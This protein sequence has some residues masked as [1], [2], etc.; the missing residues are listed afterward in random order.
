MTF[1]CPYLLIKNMLL[2]VRNVRFIKLS[3]NCTLGTMGYEAYATE[4]LTNI[5]KIRVVG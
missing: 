1:H 5:F 3:D 2:S 4:V